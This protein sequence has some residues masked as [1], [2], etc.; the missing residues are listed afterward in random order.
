M[1]DHRAASSM[2]GEGEQQQQ[3]HQRPQ[4][5]DG[6]SSGNSRPS[7]TEYWM[8]EKQGESAG[9]LQFVNEGPPLPRQLQ[10]QSSS[11]SPSPSAKEPSPPKN[12]GDDELQDSGEFEVLFVIVPRRFHFHQHS[13]RPPAPS[14][15]MHNLP[16]PA[17]MIPC[18]CFASSCSFL[19]PLIPCAAV[20]HPIGK[21]P[22]PRP[23]SSDFNSMEK[24]C[25]E[26]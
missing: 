26:R 1:A 20:P 7:F 11:P 13:V 8:A 23:G 16:M 21:C 18:T 15:H 17:I 9:R 4:Q 14:A 6:E 5:P 2:A 3:Q 19:F 25:H 22:S 12:V 24:C 10:H